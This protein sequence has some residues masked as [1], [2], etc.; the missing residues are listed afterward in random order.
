MKISFNFKIGG[1]KMK[2]FLSIS[3]AIFLFA[4]FMAGCAGKLFVE[5]MSMSPSPVSP[6]DDAVSYVRLNKFSDAV[7]TVK[8]TLREYPQ[9]SVNFTNDGTDGDEEA[10][11]NIWSK[12]V[13]IPYNA[14]SQTFHL[15]IV[16]LDKEGNVITTKDAKVENPE[17]SGTIDVKI[18]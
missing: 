12:K 3:A 2:K 6:G 11:D 7:E 4:F 17:E 13:N 8:A 1:N 18:E 10:N 16:V 15:D 14:P 5:E 9:Y